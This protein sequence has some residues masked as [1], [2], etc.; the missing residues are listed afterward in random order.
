M[1]QNTVGERLVRIEVEVQYIKEAVNEI[2]EAVEK[3]R[4]NHLV[5]IYKSI[6]DIKKDQL[7]LKSCFNQLKQDTHQRNLSGKERA[8]VITT[9]ITGAVSLFA[10]AIKIL[11]NK[12]TT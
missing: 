1:S 3:I 10:E 8:L 6:E 9:L 11:F 5:H 4:D 2:K 12:G 7:T